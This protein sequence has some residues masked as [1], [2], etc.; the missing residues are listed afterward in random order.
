MTAPLAFILKIDGPLQT[1]VVEWATVYK[2]DGDDLG[3]L[4]ETPNLY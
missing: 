3:S 1:S 2:N 4:R